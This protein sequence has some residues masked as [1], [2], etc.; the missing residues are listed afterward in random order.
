MKRPGIGMMK[1]LEKE[2]PVVD[3]WWQTETAGALISNLGGD[4]FEAYLCDLAFTW[5]AISDR[6]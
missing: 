5:S 4:T 3:T 6:G 1:M 2:V